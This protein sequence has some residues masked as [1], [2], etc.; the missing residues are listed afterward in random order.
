MASQR[1]HQRWPGVPKIFQQVWS[2]A[3]QGGRR[4]SFSVRA[5]IVSPEAWEALLNVPLF[6]GAIM[7]LPLTLG[8]SPAQG[9]HAE[10]SPERFRAPR[11]VP[12]GSVPF[13]SA[14]APDLVPFDPQKSPREGRNLPSCQI[15]R[16]RGGGSQDEQSPEFQSCEALVPEPFSFL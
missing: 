7:D 16:L 2:A 11:E 15:F 10:N 4:E 14:F 9:K 8:G 6:L 13:F 3:P 1:I 12:K 5:R